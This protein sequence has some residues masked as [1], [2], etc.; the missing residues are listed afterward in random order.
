ML[1][2]VVLDD[3][4]VSAWCARELGAPLGR[5]LFRSGHLSQVVGV[6]LADGRPAVIKI[7]PYEPRLAGCVAVQAHLAQAGFPCPAPLVGPTLVRGLAITAETLIGGGTQLSSERGAQPFAALLARLIASAPGPADVPALVQ[8]L[9]ALDLT[10]TGL[11]TVAPQGDGAPAAFARV[12]QL[13]DQLGLPERSM[14]MSDDL[15]AAVAA[16]TT[17][18]RIGRALFGERPPRGTGPP[19]RRP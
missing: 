5:V 9:S 16:G 8:G 1:A 4:A 17:M 14:G 3:A 15:D 11:M 7:R 13:A 6:E 10:V 18:V 2:D 12:A 19:S